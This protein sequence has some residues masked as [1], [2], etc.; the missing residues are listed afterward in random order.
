MADN[1]NEVVSLE[2]L[3]RFKERYDSQLSD[4][5]RAKQDTLVA[6]ENITIEGNVIS[7]SGGGGSP[8]DLYYPT[9]HGT[10]S[11]NGSGHYIDGDGGN[12]NLR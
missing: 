12:V 2:N 11:L 6:G 3:T 1:Q 8:S 5:L 4:S 9:L 7:A 10:M